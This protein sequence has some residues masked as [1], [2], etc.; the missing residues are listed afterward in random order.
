MLDTI[1]FDSPLRDH[2][3]WFQTLQDEARTRMHSLQRLQGSA[4]DAAIA[5]FHEFLILEVATASQAITVLLQVGQRAYDRGVEGTRERAAQVLSRGM[6]LEGPAAD[7]FWT[8]AAFLAGD[9]SQEA[10]LAHV[11]R[12]AL[13]REAES[14]AYNETTVNG[15]RAILEQHGVGPEGH[16]DTDGSGD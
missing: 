11:A 9:L 1:D 10:S 16:L 7:E 14:W 13:M 5:R 12:G 6:P 15:I 3:A 2:M 8:E 4:R